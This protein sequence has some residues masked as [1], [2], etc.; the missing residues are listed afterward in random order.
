MLTIVKNWIYINILKKDPCYTYY[1][2]IQAYNEYNTKKLNIN[3]IALNM[4]KT[5]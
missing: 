1:N 2:C 3:L 4:S 5:K